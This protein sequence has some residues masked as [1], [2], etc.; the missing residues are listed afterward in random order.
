M[1]DKN[2]PESLEGRWDLSETTKKMVEEFT[3]KH[4]LKKPSK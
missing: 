3:K 1:T 2:R 4:G